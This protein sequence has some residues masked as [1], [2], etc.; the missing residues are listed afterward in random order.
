MR[1]TG[2]LIF[3]KTYHLH[4]RRLN[5]KV[6][7]CLDISENWPFVL[8]ATESWGILVPWYFRKL[9]ICTT[10]DWI[11][12]YT[13]S[14]IFQKTDHLYNRRLNHDIY[15][16]LDISEN[17]PFV[18]LAT[19]SQGILVPW[20]FR[21]LTICTTGDWI[22]TYTGSMIFQKTDHLHY[23]QLNHKVYW[24][25]DISENWPFALPATESRRILFFDILENWPF[26]PPATESRGILVFWHFRK[27]I[28]CTTS[29]WIT[30]YTG[31][32]IFQKTDQRQNFDPGHLPW[33]L[34]DGIHTIDC[35]CFNSLPK[36]KIFR[37]VQVKS[38]CR[39]QNK[40]DWKIEICFGKDRKH[41]G[42]P[43]FSP[44]S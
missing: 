7:W 16:F 31:Y 6:Y 43:T 25:L 13:G 33:I 17:W 15:W 38:V 20:Y 35:Q 8:L 1:Y 3:Q 5:H 12:R 18:L 44:F 40:C 37:P 32:S 23:Q 9:T 14:L 27:L 10:G 34:E 4:H 39:R 36:D 22:T 21:K 28:I 24:L 19:E 42:L 29:D 26:A 2:F 41:F 30:T 11:M